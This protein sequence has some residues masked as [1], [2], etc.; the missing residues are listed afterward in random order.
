[1]L[2]TRRLCLG[3]C[4]KVIDMISL[5]ADVAVATDEGE[6]LQ[7]AFGEVEGGS[8]RY[9]VIQLV[10]LADDQDRRLGLDGLYLEV[11]GQAQ[12]GYEAIDRM[13]I[14]GRAIRIFVRAGT[15][16]LNSTTTPL[17]I[18]CKDEVRSFFD[19]STMLQRMGTMTGT[20]V[21]IRPG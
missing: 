15:L 14:E 6:Y 17:E 4:S 5:T 11:N 16:G 18:L 7:V 19:V 21:S 13:E 1:M 12:A 10:K 3:S 9:I 20:P 2:V 8:D